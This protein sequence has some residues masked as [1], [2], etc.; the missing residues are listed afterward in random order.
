MDPSSQIKIQDINQKE[1]EPMAKP[2]EPIGQTGIQDIKMIIA[3]IISKKSFICWQTIKLQ[4]SL[5]VEIT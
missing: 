1:R 5:M 3:Q 2:N 4:A